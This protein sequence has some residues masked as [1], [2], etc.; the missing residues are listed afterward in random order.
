MKKKLPII[1]ALIIIIATA[2]FFYFYYNPSNLREE[3]KDEKHEAH[4]GVYFGINKDGEETTIARERF[5]AI[6]HDEYIK[7]VAIRALIKGPTEEE[8]RE[9]YFTAINNDTS[10]KSI[11]VQ[12][13]IGT[14]N[15]NSPYTKE[16]AN[17]SIAS[18]QVK[19]GLLQFEDVDEVVI[20]INGEESSF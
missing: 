14:I 5:I 1:I 12:N 17:E 9:G 2:V 8:R 19:R 6:E 7:D 13:N 20:L 3:A 11:I 15:F 10:V 18:E 4:V 16:G